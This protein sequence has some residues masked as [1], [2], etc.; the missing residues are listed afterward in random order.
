M[1]WLLY[2]NGLRHEGV[3]D[4]TEAISNV[5]SD[6]WFYI[7]GRNKISF[8]ESNLTLKHDI[9]KLKTEITI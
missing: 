7:T 5:K 4:L 2:D 6:H 3:K 8:V 1:D 9:V